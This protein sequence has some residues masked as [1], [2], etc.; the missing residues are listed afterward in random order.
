LPHYFASVAI[1]LSGLL[2]TLEE[3]V[4]SR[5]RQYL[6]LALVV[7]I[8][9]FALAQDW[10]NRP[11]TET[12]V[13]K[14]LKQMT[15]EEKIGQLN[16][17]SAGS[18]TGPGTGRSDYEEMISKG[19]VG[20]L[21][22]VTGEKANTYQK[23]AVEKS[24][25][26]IPL[27]FGLDVIHGYRTTFPTPLGM[28]ATWE[29]DLVAKAARVAAVEASHDGIRWT[30][31]PMVDIA[32][33]ARWGRIVEG[34]GEDPY[35]GEAISRA[36]IRGYQGASLSDPNSIAA[37]VKHYVGYGAAEGGRDYNTTE[38]SERTLRQVY[39]PPFKAARD[40]G[41]ATF[42]SAFNALD[43]VPSSANPFTLD[44]ILRK[45]WKFRGFVVSDWTSIGE[46]IPHGIANTPADAAR[47]AL[48]AGVDMDMESNFYHTTL[49]D[50]VKSGGV[51][52]SVVD[53]A[54]R[55]ILRVK[56]ELG[57]FE[58][59]YS[60]IDPSA[61]LTPTSRELS[62][63]IAEKSFVLLRNE[64]VLP[65]K[66]GVKVALIGPLA[67]SAVDMIG[68]WN[69]KGDAK[70]VI[71]LKAALQQRLGTSVTYAKGTEIL[72]DSTSGFAEAV[73][74]AKNAD[75]AV[76]A[77]GEN[78][79]DMTGEAASRSE[80][81]IPGNQQQ[82]LK[83]IV[84][85]GKPVVLLVFSGRPLILNWEAKNV[86]AI[87]EAWHPGVEA[88]PALVRTLFGE[89]NPGGKLTTSFP[90]SVGQEPIYYNHL[91]TGR[92][93]KEVGD[94][95]TPITGDGKYHSRYI[96]QLNSPLFP[97]GFGLSYTTFAY[98]P[99]TV[100][101]TSFSAADIGRGATK[102][103]VSADVRN[104]GS[105]AGDEVVQ[106][107]ISETGTSVARPVRE[108]KGFQ[109]VTLAPGASKHV[110][111]TLGRDELAFWNIDMKNVVEP[112][113]LSIWVGGNSVD[114]QPATVELK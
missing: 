18:P 98:S 63:T 100:S 101:N 71:T 45:E 99:V 108:L 80:L 46:L 77:L 61:M 107:Y 62:R 96:D 92:P 66:A 12:R 2:E 103:A 27:I 20:S 70:D 90:R 5:R 51:P 11:A 110:E 94:E 87:L 24:R 37:C 28:S 48:T 93:M 29:P 40:A 1:Q 32:R 6:I 8:S 81:G 47:K 31:S 14:L 34:A 88:G 13:E 55:R 10:A 52:M 19:E 59:P 22:N 111:F 49:A 82:L 95:L 86:P 84:A 4:L 85:T 26:K 7:L 50:Q 91:N 39:L 76:V 89:N 41:A 112:G 106:L 9:S 56:V 114:G 102:I 44:T 43:G 38:I 58:H 73:D 33:D 83:E 36:Y 64:N 75:V 68:A 23:L 21:F 65:L 72:T 53:E 113:K 25:L 69:G 78:A 105:V 97:F 67:D 17:Y 104:S 16:Q 15:L 109:R 57:L 79:G 30:F 42:M 35:L 74:A 3:V 54:V 60:Q